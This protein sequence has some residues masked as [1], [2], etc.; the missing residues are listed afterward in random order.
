[1]NDAGYSLFGWQSVGSADK[2]EANEFRL[3]CSLVAGDGLEEGVG[4][5][6]NG[7]E[8]SER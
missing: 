2:Q 8:L 4:I 5:G 1:M 6:D 3:S 7:D